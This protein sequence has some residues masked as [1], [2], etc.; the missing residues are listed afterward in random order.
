MAD[1]SIFEKATVHLH[2]SCGEISPNIYCPI[3]GVI[4][5][6]EVGPDSSEEDWG[7]EPDWKNIPTVIFHYMSL[8]GEFTYLSSDMEKTIN[9]TRLGLG[10]DA[11]GL[12]NFEILREHVT[13]L[14]QSPLVFHIRTEGM[15]GG[16]IGM[17]VYIGLDLA[18][19]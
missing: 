7:E 15:A 4:V 5:H 2:Y 14:G 18:K 19:G 8:T 17:S 3:V 9:A 13:S 16:P 10:D 12:D 6:N 11:D 1:S